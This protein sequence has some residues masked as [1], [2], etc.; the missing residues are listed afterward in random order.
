MSPPVAALEGATKAY[1]DVKA[2]EGASISVEGGKVVGVV[3]RR[4]GPTSMRPRKPAA[5][6]S[7]ASGATRSTTSSQPSG[8]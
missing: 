3:A 8:S 1:V 4:Y 7:N 2:V 5:P 6:W